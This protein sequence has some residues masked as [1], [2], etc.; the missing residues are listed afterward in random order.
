MK[1]PKSIFI[2]LLVNILLP[3]FFILLVFSFINYYIN[4]NKLQENYI[5]E[6]TQVTN[7]VK[8]LLQVYDQSLQIFE[9]EIDKEITR[10]STTLKEKYFY[11]TDSI[12]TANLFRIAEEIEMD[13]SDLDIYIINRNGIIDNTTY[14]K[15]DGLDFYK[16]DIEFKK[17]FEKIWAGKKLVIDRFGSE[18][19]TFKIK[20]YSYNP[21]YDGKYIIE[22]GT[23]SRK[24]NIMNDKVND[25]IENLKLNFPEFTDIKSFV[26]KKDIEHP[27]VR[28]DHQQYYQEAIKTQ[29]TVRVTED[30]GDKKIFYD[31]IY[32]DMPGAVLYSGYI[33]LIESDDTREKTLLWDELIRF[34]II[35]SFTILPLF[36]LVY[37]RS[38]K[39]IQPIRMLNEKVQVI[40]KGNLDERVPIEGNNE[41]TTLSHSFNKMVGELQESY[42]TLEQKV[43]ERTL[44]LRHQKDIIEEKHREI[45]DSINYAE[46]IQRS[47]LATK[48]LLDNHL[49]DYFV[50]FNPKEVV[51]GDFYWASLLT[52]G[53]FAFCCAD[54]TGHGVPGAI[55]SI[56]NISSLEKAIETN[57]QPDKILYETRKIIIERLKKDGSKE[58]GK[59]GMDASLLV[60]NP[61]KNK[62]K[63]A[64][65]HNPVILIRQQEII[66]FKGDKM[67]VGK[68]DRDKEPFTLQE[69][70]LIKGDIIYILTD[71]FPDQFGGQKG[72]KY[73]I[74]NL[75]N[76]FLSIAHLPM[77][78][79]ENKLAN[80]LENWK[81]NNEQIDDICIIGVKIN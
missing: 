72:K 40:S 80:E 52:N 2:Q 39:I 71:G 60:L 41:I 16:I 35:M 13:T 74:K 75:K 6:Q 44:E 62:L 31:Y 79:Q 7:E 68:H 9:E 18:M 54:S 42:N 59:D 26:A 24:A 4:K 10:V 5:K 57:T 17:F 67:P 36:I 43:I 66:E 1:K 65:A 77:K 34:A 32:I 30:V 81:G 33:L 45:T 78:E 15:D 27:W 70:D 14:K 69:I 51:S 55:M 64:S 22:L 23:Y 58:G 73:M 76:Y 47:F 25:Q 46:R 28:K 20:K 56:L 61:E 50:F 12:T 38:R 49:Q 11:T 53:N 21:T 63:F 3:V 48:E 8:S 19:S 37:F 29:S